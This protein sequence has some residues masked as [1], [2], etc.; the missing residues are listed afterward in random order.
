ME[1]QPP[2][3]ADLANVYALNH[4]FLC[5]AARP[6]GPLG[7]VESLPADCRRALRGLGARARLQ[8][9]RSPFLIFSLAEQDSL[10]WDRLFHGGH[11][12]DLLSTLD[13]PDA[14]ENRLLAAT[15]GFLWQ[16]AICSPY[17]ARVVSGAPIEWCERLAQCALLEVV[18]KATNEVGLMQFRYPANAHFWR[19]LLVAG[20][21]GERAV[22]RAARLCAL[23]TLLTTD[24]EAGARRL[25]AAACAM[26]RVAEQV[27]GQPRMSPPGMRGYNTPPHESADDNGPVQDLRKR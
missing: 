19:K 9:A 8:L 23:Q 21:S 14:A 1:F 15:L 6:V 17:A 3:P 5:L 24:H 7:Q 2:Q 25:Q 18:C 13:R 11:Q 12:A 26:P 4:E 20:T 27:A 22:R 16:Q 10:R